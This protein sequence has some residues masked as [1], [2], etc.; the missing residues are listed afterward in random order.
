VT[1]ASSILP[2]VCLIYSLAVRMK[3]VR[4]SETAIIFHQSNSELIKGHG[5]LYGRDH[6]VEYEILTKIYYTIS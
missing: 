3:A 1:Q 2:T 6:G 5:K 4:A